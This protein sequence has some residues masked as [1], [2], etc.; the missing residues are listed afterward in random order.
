MVTDTTNVGSGHRSRG[1][2]ACGR[3]CIVSAI[4]G[5][6]RAWKRS[7]LEGVAHRGSVVV[8][9]VGVVEDKEPVQASP[10]RGSVSGAAER[11]HLTR[12]VLDRVVVSEPYRTLQG[13]LTTEQVETETA[14][15]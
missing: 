8:A 12:R 2:V 15:C 9:A 4:D 10:G 1:V 5:I 14:A 13:S 3:P 6:A 11:G 7:V